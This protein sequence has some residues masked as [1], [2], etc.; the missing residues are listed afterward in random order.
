MSKQRI[1]LL[2]P[3]FQDNQYTSYHKNTQ[4]SLS[5]ILKSATIT[6]SVYPFQYR[7]WDSSQSHGNCL[8]V[9]QYNFGNKVQQSYASYLLFS[10][11]IFSLNRGNVSIF[12]IPLTITPANISQ[13]IYI[14]IKRQFFANG[15]IC[16]ED[17]C[18]IK[19]NFV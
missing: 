6:I 2:Q 8:K 17:I 4:N 12:Q 16:K 3:C 10:F 9:N 19:Q 7:L 15:G 1:L 14:S 13:S 11:T 5:Y 18:L